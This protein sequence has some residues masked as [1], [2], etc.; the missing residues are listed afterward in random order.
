ME[1]RKD[2][3]YNCK[4]G[5]RQVEEWQFG[6][7]RA[8][9]TVKV[10]LSRRLIQVRRRGEWSERKRE[11]VRERPCIVEVVQAMDVMV[12]IRQIGRN[13]GKERRVGA[14]S[15]FNWHSAANEKAGRNVQQKE[16]WRVGGGQGRKEEGRQKKDYL[17]NPV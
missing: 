5:E 10:R 12:I 16:S 4:L 1:G 9:G 13:T 15:Q 14:H 6:S 8:I 11:R 2:W 3:Q 17:G 7:A